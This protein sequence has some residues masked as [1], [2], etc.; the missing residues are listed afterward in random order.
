MLRDF[1]KTAIRTAVGRADAAENAVR[2]L[3]N[4][5]SAG[6][7]SVQE[8]RM[9]C[10]VCGGTGIVSGSGGDR[11]R[12]ARAPET[13]APRPAPGVENPGIV[14]SACDGTGVTE[15]A[16]GAPSPLNAADELHATRQLLIYTLRYSQVFPA[17]TTGEWIDGLR[18]L[19]ADAPEAGLAVL[20]ELRAGYGSA[21][22]AHNPA[23][24]PAGAPA[25]GPAAG[26]AGDRS[27]P[28]DTHLFD[29]E[30]TEIERH[31]D[32]LEAVLDAI[33]DAIGGGDRNR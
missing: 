8:T 14:C 4:D 30:T 33:L 5:L 7:Q 23:G 13:D 31:F 3:S 17:R 20:T 11:A 15:D 28:P 21:K 1:T 2:A 32:T 24:G 25:S 29:R 22:Q 9:L 12:G 26:P 6:G 27:V 18:G 19:D 10:V 16:G